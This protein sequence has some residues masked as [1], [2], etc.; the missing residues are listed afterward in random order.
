MVGIIDSGI[1]STHP[2]LANRIHRS[3]PHNI[4]TTLH[5][6]YVDGIRRET[7]AIED[8]V[9]PHWHGTHVAGIIGAQWN[10][11]DSISGVAWN[12]KLVSLR[13]LDDRN[14]GT[15]EK[16]VEAVSFAGR[17]GISILNLSLQDMEFSIWNRAVL[18]TYAGLL[19]CAAG[20][21]GKDIEYLENY[22]FPASLG[23]DNMITVGATT[24]DTTMMPNIERKAASTDIGWGIGGSNW[25]SAAVH[26]F[27]PGTAIRSTMPGGGY[28]NKSGT[29]M[30]APHVTGV[31]ALL[32]PIYAS[33]NNN[34]TSDEIAALVKDVILDTVDIVPG[35]SGLC[36]TGGRLNAYEAVKRAAFGTTTLSGNN[37]RIDSLANGLKVSITD[38]LDIPTTIRFRETINNNQIIVNRSVT[39]IGESAFANSRLSQILIPASV[40]SISSY[41]FNG[42][43]SSLAA[44]WDISNISGNATIPSGITNIFAS[45][46]SN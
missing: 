38:S 29:S 11:A 39:E 35:L 7:F 28:D 3:I 2:D 17:A 30:A 45:S 23:F 37:I 9:G 20:N 19:V 14:I 16:V 41:A 43:S 31:A 4:N 33:M 8:P 21:H 34:L 26:L 36:K 12:I 1:D 13:V 24:W 27:A 25:G 32:F 6:D 18:E 22:T 46:L 10:D 5:K 40:T 44:I 42:C 15:G